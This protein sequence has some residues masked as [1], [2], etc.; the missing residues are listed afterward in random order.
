MDKSN[1]P[2]SVMGRFWR[3]L[4]RSVRLRCPLCGR[5]KLFRHGFSM[6]KAC[7]ECGAIFEREGGFFLGSIYFNYGLTALLIAIAYPILLFK[8]IVSENVL[9]LGCL[10]FAM[11]FPVLFFPLA[12]SLWLGFDQWCDPRDHTPET[13]DQA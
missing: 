2:A 4:G 5:G 1:K 12:R 10:A 11:V 8:R 9:L 13:G 7:P 6:F 3:I